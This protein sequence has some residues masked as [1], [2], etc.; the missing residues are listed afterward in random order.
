[1]ETAQ[2]SSSNSIVQAAAGTQ[3]QKQV[4]LLD[5]TYFV[6]FRDQSG[7][8]SP[9]PVGVSAALPTPQPR[10]AVKTWT[11]NPTFSG[12]TNTNLPYNAGK[13]GLFLDPA[14]GL[15]G[16]RIYADTFDLGQVYDVNIRR[17]I[18][19]KPDII[20]LAFDSLTGTFDAQ[21]G[22]FDGT[23]LD[24]IN[25]I[26][27]VRTTADN[28]AATPVWSA[29]NEYTNA[30]VRARGIQLKVVATTVSNRVGMVITQLGA[31]AEL[32]QRIESGSGAGSSTYNIT[33]ADPFYA[34]PQ[35][36]VSPSNLATGDYFTVSSVTRT[37]FTVVFTNSAGAAVTRSF[38]YTAVGYG[39]E[40]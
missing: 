9:V 17:R 12:G 3:T 13:G 32:Q 34:A 16:E 7:Q 23:D 15:T 20:D 31:T 26:T 28:P 29:W 33:F 8:R 19:S 2:W 24:Q 1:V 36:S 6:A 14:S 30:I 21:L 18:V 27:Y 11:E 38:S 35:V 4:P 40:V 25:A 39:K 10:L 37:G 5:G 22:D